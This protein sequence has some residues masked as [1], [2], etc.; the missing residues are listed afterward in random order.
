VEVKA[1][2]RRTKKMTKTKNKIN[3][4][5]KTRKERLQVEDN[6][7][8]RTKTLKFERKKRKTRKRRRKLLE[9]K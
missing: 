8:G 6:A 3:R 5:K 9:K 1:S 7:S 2:H 4:R